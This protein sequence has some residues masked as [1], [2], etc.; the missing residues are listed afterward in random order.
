MIRTGRAL[1][2]RG[3]RRQAHRPARLQG[4]AQ[5]DLPGD[6]QQPDRAEALDADHGAAAAHRR[7][8]RRARRPGWARRPTPAALWRAWEPVL[9]N[10]THDLASG[11]MTDHVYE[12]TVRSYEFVRPPGRR[13]DRRGLG[14]RSPRGSTPAARACRSSSSTRWAGPRTDVA[15]V[16]LGFAEAGV[17]RRRRDRRRPAARSRSRSSRRP[18]TPTA[19]SGRRGSRSWRAT[20]PRWAYRLST[21]S[22]R[23]APDA[24]EPAIGRGRRRRGERRSTGSPSTRPPAR[25]RACGSRT[26]TGRSSPARQRRGPAGGPGRPL[27]ALSRPRRRQQD[28]HDDPGRRSPRRGKAALQR[29]VQG[30][31]R[32][33]PPRPGLL[34]VPG[35]ATR[36]AR[37]RSRRPSGSIEGLRRI[38]CR[39][40]LVNDE[41]Y[42]RYQRPLPDHHQGRQERAR[43]PLRRDRAARRNRVPRP[44]LGRPRR[45]QHGP[46][47][48]QHRPAGQRRDRRD[49]DGLAAPGPLRWAPTA[50]AAATSRACRP[51]RASSSA[52]SG[53]CGTPWSP[54]PAT[55]GSRASTATASSSTTPCSPGSR[56]SPSRPLAGPLGPARGLVAQRRRLRP[57]AR[58][59]RG[60][61]SAGVRSDRPCGGAP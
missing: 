27:G 60:T 40:A 14:R 5:P 37:A 51:S 59:R 10:E 57:Q 25:S 15:E 31:A 30:R 7:E 22:G 45:R 58:P 41:K 8:A 54:T 46:G 48:A 21:S 17:T 36:S 32:D 11:V 35:R 2:L 28:R 38:E 16:D 9:F 3:R 26:A 47:P 4:R 53:P 20:S 29:R 55:G 52:R 33:A 56:R 23:P 1:R 49:D 18:A 61:R 6:V 39:T 19:A 13:A 44:E 42:V 50:S 34:R 12:D 43:D 24:P